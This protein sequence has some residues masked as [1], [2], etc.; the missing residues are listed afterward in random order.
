[1]IIAE[2]KGSN[3]KFFSNLDACCQK[4]NSYIRKILNSKIFIT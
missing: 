1:M 3:A 2:E 4:K